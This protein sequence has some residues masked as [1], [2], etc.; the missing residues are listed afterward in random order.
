VYRYREFTI[1]IANYKLPITHLV[2]PK[3]KSM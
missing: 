2:L 1:A 3:C